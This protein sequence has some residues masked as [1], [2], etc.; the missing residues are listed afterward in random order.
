MARLSEE[1]AVSA[2]DG[3]ETLRVLMRDRLRT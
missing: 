2:L 3:Y 1:I